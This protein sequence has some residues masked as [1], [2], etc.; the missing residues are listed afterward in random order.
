M[1]ISPGRAKPWQSI[2]AT[3]R[4]P[5]I[6]PQQNIPIVIR[7][8]TVR[9]LSLGEYRADKV[10]LTQSSFKTPSY[11][12]GMRQAYVRQV[13]TGGHTRRGPPV[14]VVDVNAIGEDS[15]AGMVGGEHVTRSPVRGRLVAVEQTGLGEEQGAG[16]HRRDPRR[17]LCS[18]REV[19]EESRVES[20]RPG[21]V[22]A[23]D[24]ERVD[25]VAR[26]GQRRQRHVGGDRHAALRA[27]RL[28]VRRR[29]H[30]AVRG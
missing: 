17:P 15:H 25:P 30:G 14:A 21:S 4:L 11:D 12:I 18:R 20:S 7:A 28:P 10:K 2:A 1:T 22:A 9:Q 29:D 19:S 27:D 16:A 13:D 3:A 24:H 8:R 5:S 6:A 23:H 26:S